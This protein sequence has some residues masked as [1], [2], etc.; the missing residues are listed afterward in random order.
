MQEKYGLTV[1]IEPGEAVALNAGFLVAEV[2]DIQQENAIAILDTS[3]ACHMPDVIEM[4]YRPSVLVSGEPG[5]EGPY[6]HLRRPDLPRR[7]HHRHL[8]LR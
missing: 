3:A 1:Y 2:L 5:G 6:L 8:L 4:P 7:R